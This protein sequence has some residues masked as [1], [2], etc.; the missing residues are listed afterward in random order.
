VVREHYLR[1][2]IYCGALICQTCDASTAHIS[3]SASPIL[4]VDTNVVLNQIDLLENT[5]MNDVVVL[6]V[7]LDEVKNKNIAVYNR[8]RMLCSNTMRQFFVFANEHHKDTYVK[9]MVGESPNDRNDR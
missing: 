9:A 7:V 1:D 2:D 3:R 5:I 8:V 6:S 4:I